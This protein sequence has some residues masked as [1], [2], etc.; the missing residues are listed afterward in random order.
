MDTMI[1]PHSIDSAFATV[2]RFPQNPIITGDMLQADAG[3]NINGPSLIAVPEWLPRP[4]GRFYLYFAH[5]RGSHV[6]LAYA[7]QLEG[8]WKIYHPGTLQLSDASGCRDHIA[9]PD[10]HV[11]HANKKIHMFFHGVE[12]DSNRQST[13]IASS[14]DGIDFV[15]NAAPLASFYLRVVHWKSVWIGMAK[16][17]VIYLSDTGMGNFRRLNNSVFPMTDLLAN[18]PGDVRHV[19][20][21]V[22][23]ET[24]Q[25]YFT[26]IGDKPERILRA[27]IDLGQPP[28]R[29]Y[30]QNY[31]LVLAPET[32][33]EG[34]DMP[35]VESRAGAATGR[36]NALRDPAI[37]AHDNRT[38]LL[39]S[40]A[41]ESGI[42]I[43][44][45]IAPASAM[46]P[47]SQPKSKG[48]LLTVKLINPKNLP[49]DT[50]RA[51]ALNQLA[52]PGR[53]AAQIAAIDRVR[54][55]KRIY[56][57]G[58]GRSGTWLLTAVMST[59]DDIHLLPL[60]LPVEHFGLVSTT[61]ST[62]VLKRN[63]NSYERI[64]EIPEQICI[65]YI[66]R[67]PYDVLTSFNPT[68]Q[69][70]RYHIAPHR[71]LS[72]M[73]ALQFLIDSK[74]KNV[75][76]IRYEDLALGPAAV[77]GELAAS[78]NLNIYHTVGE[79]TET[80]NA[81][82]EAAAAMHGLRKI[83]TNSIDRYK[84][85]PQHIDYLRTIRPRLGH[86]LDWVAN[87]FSYDIRL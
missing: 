42:A 76:I 69:H 26:R 20:L 47:A 62:L 10:V 8:P 58:C 44:E 13:F 27:H 37:F 63:W 83:D 67:H 56:I 29:W 5:H 43:A 4:L 70:R 3:N 80:F 31:E 59:F 49:D 54:P 1:K 45:M 25:V 19:A 68:T 2:R 46:Q 48:V 64:E 12:A 79:I 21:Q 60:E 51:E 82:A 74:R 55:V 11:D 81:T 33:W 38:Y 85:E 50:L 84:K 40:V 86:T 57:M 32:T 23:D 30:A 71:W 24:L 53:L 6:R 22:I 28:D 15:A 7:E 14:D 35:L 65:A 52:Q 34:A 36:E 39:Y 87:Q 16:G 77:Q 61:S 73:L 72:E 18:A 17:G 75:K 9:S 78:F 41:G 66:I